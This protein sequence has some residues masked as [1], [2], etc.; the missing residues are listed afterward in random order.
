L[1][2]DIWPALI[3][4]RPD[5]KSRESLTDHLQ[6]AISVVRAGELFDALWTVVVVSVA[7]VEAAVV[8]VVA[9]VVR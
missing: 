3:Q 8:V 9:G 6:A 5:F 4:V 1:L 2:I 7:V